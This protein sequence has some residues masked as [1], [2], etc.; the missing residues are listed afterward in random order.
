[1]LYFSLP[2]SA[3][4][5]ESTECACVYSLLLALRPINCSKVTF[6]LLQ[7]KSLSLNQKQT[8]G[9]QQTEF[10]NQDTNDGPFSTDHWIYIYSKTQPKYE[11]SSSSCITTN[12]WKRK[13]LKIA[14]SCIVLLGSVCLH[15]VSVVLFTFLIK[16]C[17]IIGFFAY[18]VTRWLLSK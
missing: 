3:S 14:C 1:M 11:E 12:N 15:C 9:K 6:F 4:R 7:A 2:L 16:M 17:I 5:M 10:I 13:R 18:V 8:K